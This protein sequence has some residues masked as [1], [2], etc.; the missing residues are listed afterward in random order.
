MPAYSSNN[1]F[2]LDQEIVQNYKEKVELLEEESSKLKQSLDQR[3]ERI[4]TMEEQ[5]WNC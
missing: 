4:N 2:S 3:T 1:V 5:V